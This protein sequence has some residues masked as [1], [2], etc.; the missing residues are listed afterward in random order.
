MPGRMCWSKKQGI[1]LAIS[2][3]IVVKQVMKLR[4]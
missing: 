1:S 2:E 4:S 3:Q